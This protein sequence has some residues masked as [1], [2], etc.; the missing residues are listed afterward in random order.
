MPKAG[1]KRTV[2]NVDDILYL[3]TGKRLKNVV[4]QGVSLFGDQTMRKVVSAFADEVPEDSPYRVLGV[5]PDAPDFLVKAAYKSHVKR[6]H[7]DVGGNAEEFKRIQ[8]AYDQIAL[9]REWT[10]H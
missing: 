10:S 8:R 4:S 7:P 3:I 2:R 9:E 1:V 6:V 5:N